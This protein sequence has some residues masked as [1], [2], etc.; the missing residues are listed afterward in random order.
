M[1]AARRLAYLAHSA[2]LRRASHRLRP[3][4]LPVAAV[5]AVQSPF[6]V[7]HRGTSVVCSQLQL[8]PAHQ[9]ASS[10]VG[11]RLFT[12]STHDFSKLTRP[13][14][15]PSRQAYAK[16]D[17]V[18]DADGV[19]AACPGGTEAVN[20]AAQRLYAKYGVAM[21]VVVVRQVDGVGT[22]MLRDYA[23]DLFNEW[24]VGT[25]ERNDG[26]MVRFIPSSCSPTPL[27]TSFAALHGQRDE[28]HGAGGWLWPGG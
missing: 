2:A 28:A 4:G 16:A 24:G 19:V 1:M 22:M 11:V 25:A 18:C 27:T 13:D 10:A 5:T 20:E 21:C 3:H 26:V 6:S 9:L 8:L 17:W 23:V 7:A 15:A 12:S 14:G